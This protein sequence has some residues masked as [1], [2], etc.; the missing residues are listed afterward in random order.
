MNHEDRL[1]ILEHHEEQI[2]DNKDR[3]NMHQNNIDDLYKKYRAH[4]KILEQEQDPYT[5]KE[6]IETINKRLNLNTRKRDQA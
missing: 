1:N 4:E 2:N 6:Q 3:I 5:L